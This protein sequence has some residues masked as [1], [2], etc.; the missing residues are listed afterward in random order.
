MIMRVAREATHGDH[1]HRDSVTE[2]RD[3]VTCSVIMSVA[4]EAT[5][6]DCTIYTT[7]QVYFRIFTPMM[8]DSDIMQEVHPDI[9]SRM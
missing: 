1:E 8:C 7:R 9:K 3:S 2:H 5:R 6:G 4:R